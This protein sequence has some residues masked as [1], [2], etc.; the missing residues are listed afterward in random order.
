MQENEQPFEAWTGYYQIEYIGDN[1]KEAEKE[2]FDA[3]FSKLEKIQQQVMLE[4][5]SKVETQLTDLEDELNIF[6]AEK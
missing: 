5:I 4:K 2:F 6:L 3:I 1:V